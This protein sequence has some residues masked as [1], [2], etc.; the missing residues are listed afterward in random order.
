MA[1]PHPMME[2]KLHCKHLDGLRGLLAVG[3]I[4]INMG[5]YNAGANT[6]VGMF[7]VLSGM[8]S[9]VA[10]GAESWDDASLAQ[11]FLRRLVR[12]L[13]MLLI[14]VAFQECALVLWLIRRGVAIPLVTSG[15]AFSFVV[16]S[17]S[18]ILVLAGSGTICRTTAVI[19]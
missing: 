14:S 16:N 15:G 8:V 6:P 13:P 12:L 2:R 9:Y 17:F 19:Y 10:Y 7:L 18:F 5:L 1:W 11:L 4:A 3:V